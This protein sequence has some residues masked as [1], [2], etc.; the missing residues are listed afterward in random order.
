MAAE[1]YLTI[2]TTISSS[3]RQVRPHGPSQG[4]SLFRLQSPFKKGLATLRPTAF[5][6]LPHPFRRQLPDAP[7]NACNQKYHVLFLHTYATNSA[8]RALALFIG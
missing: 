7:L 2:V 3:A 6:A 4:T 8:L 5:M 1:Y